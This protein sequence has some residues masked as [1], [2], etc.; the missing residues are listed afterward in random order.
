[1]DEYRTLAREFRAEM[2]VVKGSRFLALLAPASSMDE[3]AACLQ[4]ARAEFPD[5][6]HH[7]WAWRLRGPGDHFR[8]ND[9][10]EPGGSAGRPILQQID[11]H[12]VVDLSVIVVRWFGGTKLGVGG[13]MRAY[14]GAAGRA[15]DHA[16]IHTILVTSRVDVHHPYECSGAIQGMLAAWQL[17]PVSAD[18]G[19]DVHLVFDIPARDLERFQTEAIDRTAGL[20]TVS[21]S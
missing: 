19:S 15:L 13:L 11:G 9:D 1:M 7:C 17:E 18:Y 6:S 8:S 2:D 4:R 5:A 20:A 16:P 10:G 3:A 12:D 21:V 14:G